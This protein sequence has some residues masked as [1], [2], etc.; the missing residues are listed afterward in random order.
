[1][2]TFYLIIWFYSSGVFTINTTARYG[3]MEFTECHTTADAINALRTID[4]RRGAVRAECK[5][6]RNA[7]P[8]TIL[9]ELIPAQQ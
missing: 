9:H 7:S 5:G 4:N 8:A 2:T 1:M 3:P 6:V